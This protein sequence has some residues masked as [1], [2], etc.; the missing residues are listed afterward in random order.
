MTYTPTANYN[1]R[2][3][4]PVHALGRPGRLRYGA[5]LAHG[6]A[7]NDAPL[8]VDDD[9][10]STAE[11]TPSRSAPLRCWRTTAMLMVTRSS[12]SAVSATANTHGMVCPRAA[13]SPTCRPLTTDGPATSSTRSRTARAAPTRGRLAPPLRRRTT[14]RSRSTIRRA[15]P[16]TLPATRSGASANDS[17]G[18][19]EAGQTLTLAAITQPPAHGNAVVGTG[20]RTPAR[21][22]T[23]RRATT[24]AKT[25]SLPGLRQRQ[26][27]SLATALVTITINAGRG[28]P[29]AAPPLRTTTAKTRS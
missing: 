15:W 28:L 20:A 26:P 25:R 10:G 7:V 5:G 13:R 21:S 29:S 11:D 27:L 9:A 8:A 23:R 18:P 14:L 1:G 4:L 22:S 17:P 16:R 2:G 12:V 24:S 3:Q 6:D 19:N